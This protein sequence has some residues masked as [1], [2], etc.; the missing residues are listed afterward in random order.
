[1]NSSVRKL[2]LAAKAAVVVLLAMLTPQLAGLS[3]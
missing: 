2:A 1:M 3:I